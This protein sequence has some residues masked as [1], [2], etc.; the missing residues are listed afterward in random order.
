MKLPA[1]PKLPTGQKALPKVKLQAN[2]PAKIAVSAATMP[3]EDVPA[4]LTPSQAA[5]VRR[6]AKAIMGAL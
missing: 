3:Q 1:L 6:K 4:A 5:R 2:R